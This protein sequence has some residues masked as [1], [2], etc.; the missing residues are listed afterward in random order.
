MSFRSAFRPFI[1]PIVRELSRIFVR[2]SE[3]DEMAATLQRIVMHQEEVAA[4][5]ELAEK[6]LENLA[7][8]LNAFKDVISN[9]LEWVGKE[10][11]SEK[12]QID[13]HQLET[14]ELR[15]RLAVFN[16]R[17]NDIERAASFEAQAIHDLAHKLLGGAPCEARIGRGVGI[18]VPTCDRPELLAR[19]LE[20]LVS[21][22][23]LPDSVVVV[24]DGH[25]S[26]D[27]LI[28]RFLG[29]LDIR[30][31]S[32]PSPMSGSSVARNIGLDA[33]QAD[34]IAFLD[35]D[36][37]MWPN[38]IERASTFFEEDSSLDIVYGVQLRDVDHSSSTKTWFLVPFDGARLKKNNFIDL[39]QV[40]HRRSSV[41]FESSL[42]RLVDWDY[43]IELTRRSTGRITP[44]DAIAS[45]YSATE[46]LRISVAHW[47]PGLF[48][49]VAERRGRSVSVLSDSDRECSCCGYTGTFSP[50][51]RQR[52][53]AGCPRC[54]S[55]ERHRFLQLVAPALRAFWI[56]ETRAVSTTR[57]FEIAPSQ[58][59]GSFRGMFGSAITIDADPEADGRVVDVV[60]SLTDLPMRADS[61]DVLLALHVLEHIPAD[62]TA[63][64]EIA[65][66][67]S[68]TGVTVLQVPFSGRPVT[69]EAVL[70]SAEERVAR[71]GQ[72]DHV[73]F[74]G[75]DFFS[76]LTRSGLTSICVSPRQSM[77]P[78]AIKRYGLLSDE[79]LVFAVRSDNSKAASKLSIFES[80]LLKGR[81]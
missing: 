45:L 66:V 6:S 72:A 54:G 8:S 4:R 58:A 55:L 42:R 53:N 80:R 20:S 19:A 57:L 10:I 48:E 5:A 23:V 56:P 76:R 31:L 67:L 81:L 51:P 68:V 50:G 33:L 14:I 2:R 22:T 21:Q 73:R 3:Y 59:T 62:T 32:T 63:M 17:F 41:R 75:E 43:I 46:P 78:E 27:E 69:D 71:F 26:V 60:A 65:R 12:Q 25:G 35:D 16:A 44:V 61:C 18:V 24:N 77:P 38:W 70:E 7:A 9:S 39:N 64:A 30:V 37:L 15:Q 49:V 34:L 1:L 11:S 40:M 74:Y 28:S 13:T 79:G 47:P 36:N 29:R 52:P